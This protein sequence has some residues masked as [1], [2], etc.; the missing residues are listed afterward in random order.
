MLSSRRCVFAPVGSTAGPTAEA[1]AHWT[2]RIPTSGYY[3]A[4]IRW[5]SA[6]DRTAVAKVTVKG[7]VG[8]YTTYIDQRSGGGKW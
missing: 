8:W 7:A 5:T 3:D 1:W 4:C 2:P 6:S